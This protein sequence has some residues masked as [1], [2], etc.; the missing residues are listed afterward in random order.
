MEY[1]FTSRARA[2]RSKINYSS[3]PASTQSMTTSKRIHLHQVPPVP[4]PTVEPFIPTRASRTHRTR[5]IMG[6]PPRHD[7]DIPTRIGNKRS[8][9]H[10]DGWWD[11]YPP[12]VGCEHKNSLTLTQPQTSPADV[13]LSAARVRGCVF[14][15]TNLISSPAGETGTVPS[16]PRP[17]PSRRRLLLP[18]SVCWCVLFCAR[19]RNGVESAREEGIY[20]VFI[21]HSASGCGINSHSRSHGVACGSFKP[22]HKN[23]CS[24]CC[25]S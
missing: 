15:R 21:Q 20:C 2:L 3:S 10:P 13:C 8:Q 23:T 1:L 22:A 4:P 24:M 25:T 16:S 9:R 18:S 17:R 12:T 14:V 19:L 7:S 11:K 5:I 6:N